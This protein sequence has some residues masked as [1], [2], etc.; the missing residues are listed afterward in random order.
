MNAAGDVSNRMAAAEAQLL[1]GV[2]RAA[3]V[4]EE[5]V[6]SAAETIRPLLADRRSHAA[7]APV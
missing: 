1:E 4:L 7:R 5:S 3:R 6:E 2:R